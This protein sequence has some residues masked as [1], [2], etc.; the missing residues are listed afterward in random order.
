MIP[1]F[2][3]DVSEADFEYE[4]VNYSQETPVVVDFWAEW[5]GPCK[6]LGPILEKLAQ[7]GQGKFRLAKVNVDENP[8]LAMRYNVRSIPSV[9]AFRD[10]KVVAEFVGAQPEPR[11]RD[12][13]QALAPSSA[14]LIMEKASSFVE[15]QEWKSAEEA[16]RQA[17]VEKPGFPPAMMGLAKSLLAQGLGDDA[18]FILEDFPASREFSQAEQLIPLA[19]AL[20]RFLAEN[21]DNGG[22]PDDSLEAAYQRALRLISLGNLP[23]A[24]DGLLDI[25]RQDKNYQAGQARKALLGLFELLGADNPLTRQY[26]SELASILF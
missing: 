10:R 14:D 4:V 15:M 24:M 20:S 21:R 6:M 8:K 1:D 19:E 23:A 17:L 3:I 7:E 16:F 2:I 5:C 18:L 12:F 11:I 25:L 9:K 13:I 22:E 26:R